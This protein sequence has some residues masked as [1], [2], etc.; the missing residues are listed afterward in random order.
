MRPKKRQSKPFSARFDVEV[1]ERLSSRSA[2]VGQSSARLA[3][4]LID[5]GLRMDEFPGTVFRTGPTGRRAGLVGG[6]DVWEIVR[7]VKRAA[8]E[9][10]DDPVGAVSAG[11]GLERGKVELALGYY[12]AY[13]D[14]IDERIELDEE[15]A[16]RLRRALDG[17][18]SRP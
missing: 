4:R 17:A 16:N 11:T 7:D 18:A 3:E 13:P 9:G 2:R 15:A 5:E 8:R 1:V 6:P 10:V 14:E 12:G